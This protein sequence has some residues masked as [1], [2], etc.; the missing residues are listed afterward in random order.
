M[1]WYCR[2]QMVI[3]SIYGAVSLQYQSSSQFWEY[4]SSDHVIWYR[5]GKCNGWGGKIKFVWSLLQGLHVHYILTNTWKKNNSVRGINIRTQDFL[6]SVFNPGSGWYSVLFT[7]SLILWIYLKLHL[8]CQLK[9]GLWSNRSVLPGN[10]WL[11]AATRSDCCSMRC[12]AITCLQSLHWV[13]WWKSSSSTILQPRWQTHCYA[14]L[15]TL[16]ALVADLWAEISDRSPVA[17][18]G[19]FE[20]LAQ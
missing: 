10:K 20:L 5:V 18:L 4:W 7:L 9:P 15:Q 12:N 2:K 16:H 14:M 6:Q 1:K 19:A 13:S 17:V 8:E 11:I 3:H